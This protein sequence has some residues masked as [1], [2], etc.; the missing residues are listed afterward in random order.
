MKHI[1]SL[2]LL[3]FMA[4]LLTGCQPAQQSPSVKI[5]ATPGGDINLVSVFL[6]TNPA[7][8]ESGPEVQ[9]VISSGTKK[10][11]L[12]IKFQSLGKDVS[13][14]NVDYQIKFKGLVL[15]TEYDSQPSSW[16]EQSSGNLV[17][18]LPIRQSNGEPFPDGTYEAQILINEKVVAEVRWQIGGQTP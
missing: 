10:I 16:T 2:I 1:Q 13:R 6:T 8:I 4:V 9:D 15:E 12:G 11:Y 14:F 3:V 7:T 18:V 5:V 17:V